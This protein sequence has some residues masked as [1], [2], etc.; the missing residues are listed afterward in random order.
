MNISN[1]SRQKTS[2]AAE[3]RGSGALAVVLRV[4]CLV[5]FLTGAADL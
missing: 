2:P 5:P 4:F 3:R 1:S